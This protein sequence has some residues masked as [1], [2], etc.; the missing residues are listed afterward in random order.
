MLLG[1]LAYWVVGKAPGAPPEL[2]WRCG[3]GQCLA[4]GR[5]WQ[6]GWSIEVSMCTSLVPH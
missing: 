6:K 1:G 5:M 3:V 2:D 4:V